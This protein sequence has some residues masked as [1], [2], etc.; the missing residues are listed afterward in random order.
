[1]AKL[2]ASPGPPTTIG[3][4]RRSCYIEAALQAEVL[5]DQLAFLLKHTS[6]NCPLDCPHCARLAKVKGLLFA[7]FQAPIEAPS[8]PGRIAA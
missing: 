1:M 7:P 5:F 8:Q 2:I 4:G 3:E 6:P